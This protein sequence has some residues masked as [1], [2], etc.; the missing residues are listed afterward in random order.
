MNRIA[1]VLCLACLAAT[2]M[3]NGARQSW[4]LMQRAAVAPPSLIFTVTPPTTFALYATSNLMTPRAKWTFIAQGTNT[5]KVPMSMLSSITNA[6]VFGN[7]LAWDRSLDP[8]VSGYNLYYGTNSRGY[9]G[10]QN[11]GTNTLVTVSGLR[12]VKYFYAATT[13][14]KS[15]VESVFSV[16]V[17]ATA[18]PLPQPRTIFFCATANVSTLLTIKTQ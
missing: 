17:S 3:P 18:L 15:N 8:I 4:L 1:I 16:E 5:L 9:Y 11:A 13:Y 12:Q 14:S 7:M 6:P 10:R 2:K